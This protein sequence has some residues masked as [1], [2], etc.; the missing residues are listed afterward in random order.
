MTEESLDV[1]VAR[2]V[3][4]V[5]S[6]RV[7]TQNHDVI[8]T[9]LIDDHESRIRLLEKCSLASDR[10]DEIE[11]KIREIE[12]HGSARAAETATLAEELESRITSLEGWRWYVIG[13]ACGASLFIGILIN[14]FFGVI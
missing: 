3:E 12:I 11:R 2:L 13:I 5:N 14:K 1:Q 6:L 7:S 10:V 8:I 9:R 4:S